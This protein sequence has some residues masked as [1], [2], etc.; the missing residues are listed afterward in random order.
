MN[1]SKTIAALATPPGSS[2]IAVIRISG[3]EAVNIADV[4]F[5]GRKSLAEA[6]SHTIHYGKFIANGAIVDT[7][8]ASIFLAP[9]SYTGE[10]V[11]EISSHGSIVVYEEILRNLLSSG[12]SMAK[13]GEF[14]ERAFLNGKMDLIQ[15]EAVADLIS[16]VSIFSEHASA[17]QVSGEFTSRIKEFKQR[18]IDIA[19]LL[20][21]E[22]DFA[23]E[24]LEFISQ[25]KIK[26]DIE[27]NYDFIQSLI[28]SYQASQITRS[29]YYV[30]LVGFPNTGKSTLFNSLLKRER[31]IVSHIPGTTRDY[32]E[33]FL[34]LNGIPVKL[35]DTAGLRDSDDIIEIEG[36]KLVNS[37]L[38]QANMICILNDASV[39]ENL[40]NN[41]YNKLS[42]EYSS[43]KIIIV[44]NKMDLYTGNDL[45]EDQIKISAK[46]GNDLT[47]LTA[48]IES[49]A[50]KSTERI[51]D[52]LLNQR[53]YLIL[54]DVKS[55][56]MNSI[57]SIDDEMDNSFIAFDI[58]NAIRKLGE[59]TGE[60]YSEDILN[61]IFT[62]F[63]IGK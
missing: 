51:N 13:P 16:S 3:P 60:I 58:R 34:Y 2:G 50:R 61:N 47:S 24:D 22:L 14:T 15:A 12:A 45:P 6:A 49:E 44:Q 55:L 20:E 46:F 63:C 1:M 29:G 42:K 43:K 28:D 26:Q 41:L 7:I 8:T 57:S 11:V 31:A 36:I 5:A 23:E 56:L 52:I 35:F 21:L 40:S 9:N 62:K 37:I 53:Q 59:F 54:Q 27:L 48:F 38:N 17:R 32:L 25:Q 30:A 19:S 4:H 18:L 33:E 10:N 39:S